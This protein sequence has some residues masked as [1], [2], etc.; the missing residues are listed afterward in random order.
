MEEEIASLWRDLLRVDYVGS[1]DNF[2]AL[3]GH[4][5]LLAQIAG[6]IR[7]NYAVDIA[8]R[9]LFDA[10]SVAEMAIAIAERQVQHAGGEDEATQILEELKR[11]STEEL[12]A[13]LNAETSEKFGSAA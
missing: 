3:G 2:F 1:Q 11:C 7:R 4:S 6:R 10:P 9:D 12:L 13:I 8:L 5:L